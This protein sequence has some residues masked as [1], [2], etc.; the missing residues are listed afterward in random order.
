MSD[1]RIAKALARIQRAEARLLATG[2]TT[3]RAGGGRAPARSDRFRRASAS[4]HAA[5]QARNRLFVEIAGDAEIVPIVLA[6]QFGLTGREALH[7]VDTAKHGSPRLRT[8]LF[9][10]DPHP[11]RP[12]VD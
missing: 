8:L 4:I 12:S 1:P 9:G 3:A 10:H 6:E 2:E 7:I 5:K 11:A